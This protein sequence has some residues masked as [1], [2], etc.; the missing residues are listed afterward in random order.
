MK[1]VIAPDSFKESLPADEVARAIQAGFLS[2]FPKAEYHLLPIADGGEGTVKALVSA[3]KGRIKSIS[4]TGPLGIPVEAK[5]AFS[6]DGKTAFIEMA[7]ACGLHL[8]PI[9][10][11]NPL[12]TTSFGVGEL[13]LH[14]ID[15]GAKELIIGVGG[16]S[17][18]DGGVGMASALG[19]QFF[20]EQGNPVKGTGK[21][22][23]RIASLSD[24]NRDRRL[25]T[26]RITV[27]ADVDNPLTGNNGA[28][29]IYG[30]QKG[31]PMDLL[32]EMDQAMSGFFKIAGDYMET[33]VSSL[34]GSGAGGGMGAGL[35]L[36][37]GAQLRKGIDLVLEH[38]K[39]K[40]ICQDADIV[41]VG[42]GKIDSQTIFGKAP[43]GVAKCAPR[44]AKV[45]AICGSVGEGSEALYDHGFDAIFPTIPA[46]LP[47]E[48]I[49][50]GA[51]A[52]IER[53]SR[54]VAALLRNER[55]GSNG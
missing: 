14:A 20:D 31:L 13:M 45:I 38:L 7:E 42:E 5:I 52:N 41:I 54:N 16:S 22:L 49:L 51:F 37:T 21:D 4:V 40:E 17:T 48:N 19:Y 29:Y 36:F 25:D 12:H 39:V 33:D 2:I 47:I 8:V 46:M 30:P 11:R 32:N 10:S 53:T 50:S 55:D 9:D 3:H 23:F 24:M 27:A 18:N 1:V 28:T 26:V 15:Q 43:A 6:I 34:P 44:K 35:L